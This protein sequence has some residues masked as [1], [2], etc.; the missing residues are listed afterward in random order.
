MLLPIFRAMFN[1]CDAFLIL[2]SN[3]GI[4]H[5]LLG[6]FSCSIIEFGYKVNMK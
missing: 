4:K 6:S 1:E 3:D 2:E 5:N